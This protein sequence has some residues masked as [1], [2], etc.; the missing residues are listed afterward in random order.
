M[1]EDQDLFSRRVEEIEPVMRY[2]RYNLGS[3][4]DSPE[5]VAATQDQPVEVGRDGSF[6]DADLLG[7]RLA[8][9]IAEARKT[10]T[11]E[12]GSV[13]WRGKKVSVRS[14]DVRVALIK[15]DKLAQRLGHSTGEAFGVSLSPTV[16]QSVLGL[17][18]DALSLI[19]KEAS[20]LRGKGGSLK[21][22]EHRA[23]LEALRAYAQ[24]HKLTLMVQRNERLV[25]ELQEKRG[26]VAA[27]E[28]GGER[29]LVG[30]VTDMIHVYDAL[31]Q[32]AR[33][34]LTN[35]GGGDNIDGEREK[36][37]QIFQCNV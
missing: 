23:E 8:S 5:G 15:A 22:E 6:A 16:Y 11:R 19:A 2:C 14:E 20:R 31:L 26:P 32:G 3:G 36:N 30:E 7:E 1:I 18:D 33:D 25:L 27:T 9:V 17:Y 34:I 28:Q 37:G 35:L 24:H 12:L 4:N 10:Q 21:I 13:E 29:N